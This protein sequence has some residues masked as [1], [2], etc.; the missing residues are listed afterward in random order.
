M[1]GEGLDVRVSEAGEVIFFDDG[2]SADRLPDGLGS[3]VVVEHARKLRTLYAGL[4]PADDIEQKSGV[5][6]SDIIGKSGSVGKSSKPG[7]SFAVIDS[8]FEQYVNPLLILN[9]IVDNKSPVVREVGLRTEAGYT[10]IGK[11]GTVKAGK[12]E[13]IA[14]V[15]DPCMSDDFFCTMAPYK[16]HLFRNGEEIFYINFESLR[17]EDAGAVIQSQKEVLY[18]DYYRGDGFISLGELTLV[19]GDLRFEILVSD[20]SENENTYAFQLTVTE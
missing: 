19:P 8:E 2:K 20:Y 7:L 14:E 12:A 6:A 15:F 17:Y 11:K 1:Y 16:I 9:S 18:G 4:V 5:S 10:K 13:L 3:Y